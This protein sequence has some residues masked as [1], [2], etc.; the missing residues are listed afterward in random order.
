MEYEFR[1]GV[2]D[3]LIVDVKSAIVAE[4]LLEIYGIILKKKKKL[5]GVI[6]DVTKVAKPPNAA[7]TFELIKALGEFTKR[8]IKVAALLSPE[9]NIKERFGL[10]VAINR[11]IMYRRFLDKK[12]AEDWI[13]KA[14]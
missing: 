5:K 4:E 12:S 1:K 10:N 14:H 2:S 13:S 9:N 7:D 6:F 3:C 11:G 8:N